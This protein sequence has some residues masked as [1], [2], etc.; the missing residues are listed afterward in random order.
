MELF[1]KETNPI[2]EAFKTSFPNTIPSGIMFQHMNFRGMQISSLLHLFVHIKHFYMHTIY[3]HT[4]DLFLKCM[5]GMFPCQYFWV[6]VIFF[7]FF[8]LHLQHTEVPSPRIEFEWQLQPMPQLQQ[9][10]ILN[11]LCQACGSKLL[12]PAATETAIDP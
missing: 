8:Q 7:F 10:Q 2:H 6:Y 5:M 12:C 4:I 1:W 3:I 11:S 9:C